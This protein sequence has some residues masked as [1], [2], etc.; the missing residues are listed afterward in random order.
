MQVYIDGNTE[1]RSSYNVIAKICSTKNDAKDI[2]ISAHMDSIYG[3]GADDN[4]SG[5]G[6]ALELAKYYSSMSDV[7]N[8]NIIFVFFGAEEMGFL[9]SKVYI[10]EHAKELSNCIFVFNID[11]I[12][13]KDIFI[14]SAG[15]V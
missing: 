6:A 3:V 9:E 14:E 11:A 1:E 15:G 12:G 5:V 13:G 4:A 10:C 8:Y 2:I 7:F